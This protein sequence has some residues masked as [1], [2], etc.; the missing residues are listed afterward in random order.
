M[1]LLATLALTA[2]LLPL[3]AQAGDPHSYAQPDKVVVT[4][5]DLD[6]HMDFAHR[7]LRGDATLSLHWKDPK[8]RDLVLDTS[9]LKIA[10]VKAVSEDGTTR[11]L[12]YVLA[13]PQK[14]MGR[15]L[16]IAAPNHPGMVRIAYST[17]PDAGGLQW[18]PPAQTADKKH[19]FMFSQSESVYARSWIPLQDSPAV[20]FTYDA[21]IT[22][23]ENLRVLMSAPN[24]PEHPLDGD[25]RFE[26]THPIPSYLMAIAAGDIDVRQTGPRSAVY[27]EPSVVAKAAHEFEDTE[28]MIATAESLYGP[29]RWGRYD[30][31]VLPPSFPYG[32]MENPNMTFATPTVLVG[33]KSLV[34]LVAHELAHS[35]SGNLVT[36]ATWRD[37]WLNEGF[38][39]Y[40]QGRITE[41]LYGKRLADEEV[42]LSARALQKNIGHMPP[43]SQ[44]LA[45]DPRGVGAD[46]SLSDVAYDK[47]S[48]FLR[49]LE[50]RFGRA[51]FDAYLK[52]YFDHFAWHSITTEQM[53]AYLKPHLIDKYPGKMSW[54]EVKQWVYGTGIPKD[55][56]LPDSPRFDAIDTE[57]AAFLAG[58]LPAA[59]LDAKDWNTQEWMYFL[60]RLPD[61]PPLAKMKALDAAW[62]LTGT[63]NAEIGMRWYIHAIAAGDKAVW[64]AAAEHMTRIGRLYLT[65]PLYRALA[66]T[67]D[68]LAFAR[69]VYA[70]ARSGYHPLTQEAVEKLFA[71]ADRR[72]HH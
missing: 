48:W 27:A 11:K 5:L 17:S 24:D 61:A 70:Q 18:L 60:D 53:L 36:A 30:I 22:A 35:W 66:K 34:S 15:K 21:H 8:A 25:F 51:H 46:D 26:Q 32:G 56:K 63:P 69:K 43:N 39:T 49:T 29:Y 2:L 23:P 20:R 50:R 9:D 14:N 13:P 4:H 55:A 40:V 71:R 42:L 58:T 65:L 33:D 7:E 54:A 12:S 72:M 28:K 19:P 37:I 64:P 47:G 67:P 59:K 6:L 62:H 38:T 10:S 68:G 45:P 44:K 3:T 31:L 16:T 57:R 41:A 52:G 1:R